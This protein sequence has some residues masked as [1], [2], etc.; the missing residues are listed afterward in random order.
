[1]QAWD[2]TLGTFSIFPSPKLK[3]V[4]DLPRRRFFQNTG[5]VAGTFSAVGVIGL[6]III[7]I[8]TTTIRR[9]RAKKFDQEI[10]E[11]AREAAATQPPTFLDDDD[12]FRGGYGAGYK[13]GPYSDVSSHGTYQQS[14]MAPETYGMREMGHGPAPGE[15]FDYNSSGAGAAGIGVA[16]A[17]SMTGNN[18]NY[19]QALQDGASPYAAFHVPSTA[20]PPPQPHPYTPFRAE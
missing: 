14:P 16:R 10:A 7:I 3:T 1:M 6:I 5:A 17:R 15:V 4:T 13:A 20:T 12:D 2:N 11:A 19:G 18:A 8:A 9:R